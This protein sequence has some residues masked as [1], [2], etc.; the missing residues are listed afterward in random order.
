ML[1]TETVMKQI[2]FPVAVGFLYNFF[3]F[4][5]SC[6]NEVFLTVFVK[7]LVQSKHLKKSIANMNLAETEGLRHICKTSII[8]KLSSFFFI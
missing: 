8:W 4:L 6:L 5:G 3:N 1:L 2:V 7:L